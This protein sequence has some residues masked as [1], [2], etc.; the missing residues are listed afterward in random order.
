MGSAPGCGQQWRKEGNPDGKRRTLWRR[1]RCNDL[2]YFFPP[3]F[4]L[5]HSHHLQS[6]AKKLR[7]ATAGNSSR[8][9]SSCRYWCSLL[10]RDWSCAPGLCPQVAIWITPRNRHC[11]MEKAWSSPPFGQHQLPSQCHHDLLLITLA[12][13]E[14]WSCIQCLSVN[15][16][17]PQRTWQSWPRH[18]L[19]CESDVLQQLLSPE[20]MKKSLLRLMVEVRG[21]GVPLCL[22]SCPGSQVGRS[23]RLGPCDAQHSMDLLV[24]GHSSLWEEEGTWW[25]Q[26]WKEEWCR[27]FKKK[28]GNLNICERWVSHVT[29]L[30]GRHLHFMLLLWVLIFGKTLIFRSVERAGLIQW[31]QTFKV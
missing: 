3:I 13:C 11:H 23:E 5:G 26:R 18:C 14:I 6:A 9:S 24:H 4:S 12:P 29:S 10:P 31:P 2:I 27:E 17:D 8:L 20:T 21:R 19:P 16:Q 1:A 30:E 7:T 15:L 28:E 25:R 22:L